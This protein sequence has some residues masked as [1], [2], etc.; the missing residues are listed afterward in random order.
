M[1]L[2]AAQL[3]CREHKLFEAPAATRSDESRLNRGSKHFADRTAI[4]RIAGSGNCWLDVFKLQVKRLD[5]LRVGVGEHRFE[6]L[7][8]AGT[9][10]L[11]QAAISFKQGCDCAQVIRAVCDRHPCVEREGRKP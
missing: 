2:P 3:V 10:V 6:W 1:D 11:E 7:S 5:V 9:E 4:R 8:D